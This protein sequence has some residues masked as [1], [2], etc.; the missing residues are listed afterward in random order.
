LLDRG[1]H[2]KSIT[3]NDWQNLVVAELGPGAKRDYRNM[4]AGKLLIPPPNA[5]A[6][7]F[8]RV[9]ATEGRAFEPGFDVTILATPT[10]IVR[11]VIPGSAAVLAGLRNGDAV[12]E[13]PDL[14]DPT[15]D[16]SKPITM[17][18]RRG[19]DIVSITFKPEGIPVKGYH[20]ER[21]PKVSDAA[22][23]SGPARF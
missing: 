20:W 5:F 16:A 11:G 7:C 8:R 13:S 12:T 4:V 23:E 6:P 10:R 3:V 22:C 21:N 1:R 15:V 14:G 17:K 19:A 2:K 9:A 18:V